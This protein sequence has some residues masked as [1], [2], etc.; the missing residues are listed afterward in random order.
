MRP[1]HTQIKLSSAMGPLVWIPFFLFSLLFFF[2]F[3]GC[4]HSMHKLPGQE[5]HLS[6]YSDNAESLTSRP[7]GNSM[8][9]FFWW[10]HRWKQKARGI[11]E[12]AEQLRDQRPIS[13][14]SSMSG[15]PSSG[16]L[17]PAFLLIHLSS[18]AHLSR[19]SHTA[20]SSEET[21]FSWSQLIPVGNR[22]T[23]PELPR[24]AT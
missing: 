23:V 19:T 10:L 11:V 5:S 18:A 7:P 15:S 20:S 22:T 17:S 16:R 8:G 2:F 12:P 4:T 21:S 6:H 9:F 24:H 14:G 1:R 3:F 13:H